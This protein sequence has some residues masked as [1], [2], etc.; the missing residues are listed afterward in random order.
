MMFRKGI[1]LGLATAMVISVLVVASTDAKP[2]KRKRIE[3]VSGPPSLSLTADPTMVKAC[4]DELSR[5]RLIATASSTEGGSLRYRWTTNRGRLN[6]QGANTTWDLAG[7]QPGVYQAVAEVD[8]GPALDCVAFSSVSVIV[9]DCP[10]PP[11]PPPVCPNV[12]ISCPN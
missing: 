1:W 6:G 9:T 5:V 3:R 11:P 10:P 12:T 4:A 7:V 8:N 2:K